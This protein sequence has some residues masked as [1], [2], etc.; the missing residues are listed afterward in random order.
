MIN[1]KWFIICNCTYIYIC[2]YTY[3]GD[4]Q[5]LWGCIRFIKN[6]EFILHTGTRA[7]ATRALPSAD[8]GVGWGGD[9]NVR[10]NLHSP[11]IPRWPWGG[12]GWEL[13]TFVW[14]CRRQSC[15]AQAWGGDG[16][17]FGIRYRSARVTLRYFFSMVPG[18]FTCSIFFLSATLQARG[19]AYHRGLGMRE[20]VFWCFFGLDWL[21]LDVWLWFMLDG[22]Y[23]KWSQSG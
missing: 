14:C 12:V 10:V 15:Y 23:F 8:H 16:V 18:G 11:W 21:W 7:R 1:W 19:S 3:H 9:V 13:L 17:G 6:P 2:I 22:C 20:G 5:C 4:W